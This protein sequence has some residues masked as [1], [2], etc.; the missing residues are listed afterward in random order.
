[1]LVSYDNNDVPMAEDLARQLRHALDTTE[2]VGYSLRDASVAHVPLNSLVDASAVCALF[3]RE[4]ERVGVADVLDALQ[5]LQHDGDASVDKREWLHRW[6]LDPAHV[7]GTALALRFEHQTPDGSCS[8]VP[9]GAAA[10]LETIAAHPL[11]GEYY[12]AAMHA[13]FSCHNGL[14]RASYHLLA[15]ST[16]AGGPSSY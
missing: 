15:A 8:C 6:A 5:T 1:M 7:S 9:P 13:R 11:V 4:S 2:S 10:T 16:P 3:S 14:L 12:G